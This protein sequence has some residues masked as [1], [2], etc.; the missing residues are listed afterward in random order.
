MPSAVSAFVRR[1]RRRL[2]PS[3]R[4]RRRKQRTPQLHLEPAACAFE[5]PRARPRAAGR[6][7][8]RSTRPTCEGTSRRAGRATRATDPNRQCAAAPP[9]RPGD[10]S[11]AISFRMTRSNLKPRARRYSCARTSSCASP[12]SPPSATVTSTIGRSPGDAVL[13]QI[14]RRA[15]VAHHGLRRAQPR[16]GIDHA[17]GKAL[18]SRLFLAAHAKMAQLDFAVRAGERERARAD[19]RVVILLD[20]RAHAVF[21]LGDDGGERNASGHAGRHAQLDAQAHDRIE[22]GARG[23]RQ[24]RGR[25]SARPALANVPPRPMKCS[26]S[27]S[28][29]TGSPMRPRPAST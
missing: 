10:S 29:S 12:T 14:R 25:S 27:V 7:P 3:R 8:L 6:D 26:R 11:S 16:V 5:A 9:A 23:A 22:H 13:P 24:R 2:Y 18:E 17:R 21:V 15:R 28:N 19:L 1:G 4:K 20:E